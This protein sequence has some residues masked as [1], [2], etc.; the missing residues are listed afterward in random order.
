[1][2]P[3]SSPA[4]RGG[5][6][7][8]HGAGQSARPESVSID[9]R[10]FACCDTTTTVTSS[11]HDNRRRSRRLMNRSE[12][13]QHDCLA[14][15]S[16][17]ADCC[18]SVSSNGIFTA[19]VSTAN[20]T[21]STSG[22]TCV[23][24]GE[25]VTCCDWRTVASPAAAE[26]CDCEVRL[27]LL[28]AVS[29][30]HTL[31]STSCVAS[32]PS[33]RHDVLSQTS[34][35]PHSTCSSAVGTS[36]APVRKVS[37][38][39]GLVTLVASADGP[40]CSTS[41]H[42]SAVD[43][44]QNARSSVTP[45]E[46]TPNVASVVH[47][48]TE[49]A[50][51]LCSKIP[52]PH[53]SE[54]CQPLAQ[55]D[56]N[57]D[58]E[59]S[60]SPTN[61]RTS[62]PSEPDVDDEVSHES[63]GVDSS[64][65]NW[66][67]MSPVFGIRAAENGAGKIADFVTD[68]SASFAE[69]E[70][71]N[72]PPTEPETVAAGV[73]GVDAETTEEPL[74]AASEMMA[75]HA[76]VAH[77]TP[78]T[79][80]NETGEEIGDESCSDQRQDINPEDTAAEVLSSTQNTEQCAGACY[81]A[82]SEDSS[83]PRDS[84]SGEVAEDSESKTTPQTDVEFHG[85]LLCDANQDSV[86]TTGSACPKPHAASATTL[87]SSFRE[88]ENGCISSQIEIESALPPGDERGAGDV[89]DSKADVSFENRDES[90]SCST[91]ARIGA[92]DQKLTRNLFD[93]M[94]RIQA[95][96]SSSVVVDLDSDDDDCVVI[97]DDDDE[98]NVE[99]TQV[100][101]PPV[102]SD[103]SDA[104]A[105]E[106]SSQCIEQDN[107]TG[108]HPVGCAVQRKDLLETGT[109]QDA[110]ECNVGVPEEEAEERREG[111]VGS[112]EIGSEAGTNSILSLPED[113]VED[114]TRSP[115]GVPENE[116]HENDTNDVVDIGLC[117]LLSPV[118]DTSKCDSVREDAGEGSIWRQ[119]LTQVTDAARALSNSQVNRIEKQSAVENVVE[120]EDLN[121]AHCNSENSIEEV[122]EAEVNNNATEENGVVT[123]CEE[124]DEDNGESEEELVLTIDSSEEEAEDDCAM[125]GSAH[126]EEDV[127]IIEDDE[128]E[129]E[130]TAT[131]ETVHASAAQNGHH[132]GAD[133]SSHGAPQ[134]GRGIQQKQAQRPFQR[135]SNGP[136]TTSADP[137][138][139]LTPRYFYGNPGQSRAPVR[140]RTGDQSS[141]TTYGDLNNNGVQTNSKSPA[142]FKVPSSA[143]RRGGSVRGGA[144]PKRGRSAAARRYVVLS[145]SGGGSTVPNFPAFP[146]SVQSENFP[147][148]RSFGA[149]VRFG[150]DTAQYGGS[151]RGSGLFGARQSAT[152]SHTAG[153]GPVFTHPD[154]AR[155]G[156]EFV[157][158]RSAVSAGS[159][160]T[161]APRCVQNGTA[162]AFSNSWGGGDA[163]SSVV[164]LNSRD[165]GFDILESSRGLVP[166]SAGRGS[167][168]NG[169][170]SFMVVSLDG[171]VDDDDT[172]SDEAPS[173]GDGDVVEVSSDEST[174]SYVP[175][176]SSKPHQQTKEYQ[177][178]FHRMVDDDDGRGDFFY[179]TEDFN[180]EELLE[181]SDDDLNG[182]TPEN[183][184][185]VCED[186]QDGTSG[187]E[188]RDDL[189]RSDVCEDDTNDASDEEKE[190][191]ET[192]NTR[193][194]EEK[195]NGLEVS[196]DDSFVA[197]QQQLSDLMAEISRKVSEIK[198]VLEQTVDSDGG[199]GLSS[200]SR[201][202][203][204][205]ISL[206]SAEQ[207]VVDAM[208]T[209]KAA[210]SSTAVPT[211]RNT[212]DAEARTV[213]RG[214]LKR[215]ALSRSPEK[216]N[217][218][219][220]SKRQKFS[221]VTNFPKEKY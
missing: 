154:F 84:D 107:E 49:D 61:G 185:D 77:E 8:H 41:I 183:S 193:K 98:E 166:P 177:E 180:S 127:V 93:S 140:S 42:V 118:L 205:D 220:L 1:M 187:E 129:D 170:S 210:I 27:T 53:D 7:S 97:D 100:P 192:E 186:D 178:R 211:Q 115:V 218:A 62:D 202:P 73:E 182:S 145:T 194:A 105:A 4:R 116:G 136:R 79:S 22:R 196:S 141:T 83:V 221:D 159:C 190:M 44:A 28:P 204:K 172:S 112:P 72:A 92:S 162:R 217:T 94:Y 82:A 106:E 25:N 207:D 152:T 43:G 213:H 19:T 10:S 109:E 206:S 11:T 171:T 58:T 146:S 176:T 102:A 219:R 54:G 18:R 68:N 89:G 26:C 36:T 86:E 67:S 114:D 199:S 184:S 31:T 181:E 64:S 138:Q 122:D 76:Q 15:E 57:L 142:S 126:S 91:K 169:S 55:A 174:C 30:V 9:S 197:Q 164:E 165:R 24:S 179:E 161:G 12:H 139:T 78:L 88:T 110:V 135:T 60:P 37:F 130:D 63:L 128:D 99:Q 20:R 117:R 80:L 137:E 74:C 29:V 38:V 90:E 121:T 113:N 13:C 70:T 85:V 195:E 75:S 50:T 33:T 157:Q 198:K 163:D 45:D 108:R 52:N 201:D 132:L 191:D 124:F 101:Q 120:F 215:R 66:R 133:H 103:I 147:R 156:P 200:S 40:V 21:S 81:V 39:E 160:G 104:E 151:A 111:L 69:T 47:T 158:R 150:N 65:E 208:A 34:G 189:G 71:Q 87:P 46:S 17:I 203:A 131:E 16:W 168:L 173:S 56:M 23:S 95:L 143:K 35:E 96:S 6:C 5:R 175:G 48:A 125:N 188:E 123:V 148:S 153:H 216:T 155:F 2:P 149:S 51:N 214:G 59:E 212:P 119:R 209:A 134:F 14:H 3:S 32:I 144:A 167:S